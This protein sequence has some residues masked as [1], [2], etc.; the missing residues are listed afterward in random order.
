MFSDFLMSFQHVIKS[1]G[2]EY[3]AIQYLRDGMWT[4]ARV[5]DQFPANVVVVKD[6]SYV[7]RNKNEHE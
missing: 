4:A 7:E 2:I 6:D 1:Q 3:I 5:G